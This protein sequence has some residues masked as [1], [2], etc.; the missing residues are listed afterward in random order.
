[1]EAATTTFATKEIT[2]DLYRHFISFQ[3]KM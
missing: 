2:N 3:V 1:M